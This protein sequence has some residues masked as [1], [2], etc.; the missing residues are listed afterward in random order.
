MRTTITIDDALLAQAAEYSGLTETSAIVRLAL[1]DYISGEAS[2]R[3]ARMGASVPDFEPAAR[4]R[5]WGVGE[6]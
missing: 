2:R 3:L 5:P 6:E 4:Q 1:R